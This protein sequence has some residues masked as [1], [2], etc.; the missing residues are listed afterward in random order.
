[1]LIDFGSSGAPGTATSHGQT[2]GFRLPESIRRHVKHVMP[3]EDLV[4]FLVMLGMILG[5]DLDSKSL[6]LGGGNRNTSNA[7]AGKGLFDIN[8]NFVRGQCLKYLSGSETAY[9]ACPTAEHL[10]N[11]RQ[12][13]FPQIPGTFAPLP[14][15][16]GNR[17]HSSSPALRPR[18]QT[19]FHM[20][21]SL[22]IVE[23]LRSIH[24]GWYHTNAQVYTDIRDVMSSC[25]DSKLSEPDFY[26]KLESIKLRV[27][28]A[29]L[30]THSWAQTETTCTKSGPQPKFK[31]VK[32]KFVIPRFASQRARV[33]NRKKW[34]IRKERSNALQQSVSQRL[35]V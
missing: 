35:Q 34:G 13:T 31:L 4:S 8:A 18:V 1:M 9:T 30:C 2:P 19:A 29:Q 32:K 17:D 23:V 22:V 5:W 33:M 26:L 12:E 25:F 14:P 10:S 3:V 24:S 16:G 7:P 21:A 6:S 15:L 20:I 27:C 11:I 28:G